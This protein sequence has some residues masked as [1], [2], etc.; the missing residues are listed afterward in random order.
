MTD[1][2]V[3]TWIPIIFALLQTCG[4]TSWSMLSKH[5]T[6]ERI[7]FDAL[8]VTFTTIST[9]NFLTAIVAICY[10]NQVGGFNM[11]LFWIG[12]VGSFFDTLGIVAI[13]KAFSCGPAGLISALCTSTNILLTLIEAL[14]R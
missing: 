14:R 2:L 5:I 1:T 12:M 3:P 6:S 9:V 8:N 11:K 4:Y 10:F 7:G 13:T